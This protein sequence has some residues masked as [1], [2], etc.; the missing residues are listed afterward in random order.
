MFKRY[1][2]EV[3]VSIDGDRATHNLNRISYNNQDVYD[4]ILTNIKRLLKK[5][6]D[7][8]GRMTVTQNNADRIFHNVVYLYN[9][10]IKHIALGINDFDEWDDETLEE[11]DQGLE[12]L[13]KWYLAEIM[14]RSDL[15]VD[16]F[17]FLFSSFLVERKVLFCSAGR[18]THLCINTKGDIYPC[19]YVLNNE[20]WRLGDIYNGFSRKRFVELAKIKI[21][22]ENKCEQCRYKYVCLSARCGFLNYRLSGYLNKAVEQKCKITEIIYK[23]LSN[24]IKALYEMKH[25]KILGLLNVMEDNGMV[26]TEIAKEIFNNNI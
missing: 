6:I 11:L 4:I 3:R 21:Y 17:D 8:D 1:N 18:K 22:S 10:G 26:L 24:V 9:L 12:Y 14:Q 16:I 19:A 25:P 23:H 15:T 20:E 13:S 2:V 7:I 5:K